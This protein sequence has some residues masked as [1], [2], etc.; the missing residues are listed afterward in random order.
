MKKFHLAL[1]ASFVVFGSWAQPADYELLDFTHTD[2]KG[3]EHSLCACLD[4][5]RAVIIDV[6]AAWCPICICSIPGIE[7]IYEEHGPDGDDPIVVLKYYFP[8]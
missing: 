1:V 5:G 2:I 7:T 4:Q 6:F 8:C 3:V